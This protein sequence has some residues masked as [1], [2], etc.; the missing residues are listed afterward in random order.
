MN[1]VKKYDLQ[2]KDYKVGDYITSGADGSAYFSENFVIKFV[3]LFDSKNKVLNIY[4][5]NKRIIY[6]IIDDKPKH[7]VETFDFKFVKDFTDNKNYHI[8]YYYVMERLNKIS[9]DES[10]LFHTIMSHEDSNKIK[11]ISDQK[12]IRTIKSL[13]LYLDF[14]YNKI[15]DFIKNIENYKIK[16]LDVHPRNIMKDNDGNFKFI[17]LERLEERR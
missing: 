7:Y 12:T 3:D 5:K 15:I 17:D 4:S 2:I 8:I 10:K 9:E 14:D 13:N 11:R 6:K 1:I 16:H